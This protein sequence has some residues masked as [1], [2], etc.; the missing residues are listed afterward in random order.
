VFWLVLLSAVLALVVSKA[1]L[2]T[3]IGWYNDQGHVLTTSYCVPSTPLPSQV[4]SLPQAYSCDALVTFACGH[5]LFKRSMGGLGLEAS[6]M[7][8]IGL[9]A[10]WE[11]PGS[12]GG[13]C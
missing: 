11:A 1:V 9:V 8:T 7:M 10:P 2:P 4:W 3:T 12:M 5:G 6:T 13:S